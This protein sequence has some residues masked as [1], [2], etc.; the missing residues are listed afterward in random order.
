[1]QQYGR[2]H[3]LLHRQQ[4]MA[5]AP[6]EAT[7]DGDLEKLTFF[8]NQVH[9]H[10][11]HNVDAYPDPAAMVDVIAANLEG[12]A[13][14]WL[15]SLHNEQAPELWNLNL[16]I[17]GLRT[18]FEN[19]PIALQAEK[20][21]HE[22]KQAGRPVKEYVREF[23]RVAGLIER[24]PERSLV[25]HFKNGLDNNLFQACIYQGIPDQL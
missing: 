1:M 21:I 8:L 2:M 14:E 5:A 18:R 13:S 7:F 3:D 20:D 9:S 25:H 24:W 11:N 19:E 22:V 16:F 10:V 4:L 17:W 23:R 12:E 15:N 6:F